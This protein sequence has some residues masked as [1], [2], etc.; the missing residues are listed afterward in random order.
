VLIKVMKAEDEQSL[1]RSHDLKAVALVLRARRDAMR[2]LFDDVI[3]GIPDPQ[4]R[5]VLQLCMSSNGPHNTMKEVAGE[6]GCEVG[7]V[8][9]IDHLSREA[10]FRRLPE[11]MNS[12]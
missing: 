8:C 10:I 11:L 4:E 7:F 12:I 2:Q 3:E 6:V 5:R 1:R 9:D